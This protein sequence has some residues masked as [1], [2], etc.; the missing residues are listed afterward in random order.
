MRLKPGGSTCCSSRPTNCTPAEGGGRWCAPRRAPGFLFPVHALSRVFRG[1]FLQALAEA[2]EA[3][4]LARDPA[5]TKT[6]RQ[7]RMQVLRRHDW[8]VY[9]KTPLAGPAAALRYLSRYTQSSHTRGWALRHPAMLVDARPHALQGCQG[10]SPS[11]LATKDGSH[12]LSH[13]P[14]S[15]VDAAAAVLHRRTRSSGHRASGA[16]RHEQLELSQLRLAGQ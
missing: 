11:R 1:K 2:G 13:A 10:E 5:R 9:A 4:T 3:G 12:S 15:W 6:A 16:R 8:V 14:E 7:Q